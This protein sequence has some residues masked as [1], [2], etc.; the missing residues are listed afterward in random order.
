MHVLFIWPNLNAEEGFSHGVACLSGSLKARGHRTSLLNLNEAYG[1]VPASEQIVARI[2]EL[3]PDLLAFS[4]MSQQYSYSLE[5]ARAIRAALP[6]LPIA[7]GGV[8]TT[9]C[10]QQVVQDGTQYGVWDYIGV[11]ECDEALPMLVDRLER[12]GVAGGKWPVTSDPSQLGTGYLP[13]AIAHDVPNFHVRLSDSTYRHNPLGRYPD[14]NALPQEDYEIFDLKGMLQLKNG[15][16]SVLTSRGCPYRCSYCLNHEVSDRYMYEAGQGRG[17]YL[18]RYDV[19]RIIPEIQVLRQRHPYIRMFIFDDDLFTLD[20]KY[21]TEFCR[22]YVDAGITTPFV[23]NAH[24]QSFTEPMARALAAS[25]CMIVKFGLESGSPVLRS[26][27]LDRHMSNQQIIDAFGLCQS[28]GLHSSAFLMFGLPFETRA[29]MEETIDLVARIKPGRMRWAIFYPFAGTKAYEI[30]RLAGL[31]DHARMH[32][33]D[34]YFVTSCLKFDPATDLFIQ[35][36]QRTFHW[37]VNARTDW[38][39]AGA[40]RKMVEEVES[41]S[42]TDWPAARDEILSRDRSLSSELLARSQPH[43]SIRYTEVMAVHSDYLL[44]E[45]GEAKNQAARR[46]VAFREQMQGGKRA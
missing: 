26:K 38:Q 2:R 25:P 32:A 43:Y 22:A 28:H 10:T 37:H 35:K 45:K 5:L 27:A 8:H 24:V 9:M 42:A 41:V 17:Q 12:G 36:L 23:V 31:I 30:C 39:A 16:Q 33:M 13:P 11:G 18:R 19:K 4:V 6:G 46:W 15:W 7:I 29:M 3:R 20:E 1:P 44:A 34:N 21:V 40:Y 14:L